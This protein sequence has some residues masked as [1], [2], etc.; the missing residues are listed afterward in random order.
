MVEVTIKPSLMSQLYNITKCRVIFETQKKNG[1]PLQLFHST[2][3][4]VRISLKTNTTTNINSLRHT[5]HQHP[6]LSHLLRGVESKDSSCAS[7]R[8]H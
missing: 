1:L 2:R 8:Q 5:K 4:S 7:P 6:R 3:L